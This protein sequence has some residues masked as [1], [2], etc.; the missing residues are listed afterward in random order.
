MRT[1]TEILASHP[2]CDKGGNGPN[3][4][5]SYDVVYEKLLEHKRLQVTHVLEVG[6][7]YGHSL[8]VWA[9]YFPNARIFG[10]DNASECPLW[11]SDDPRIEVFEADTTKPETVAAVMNRFSFGSF[12]FI[13]DDGLHR[14]FAQAV[15]YGTLKPYLA[16]DGTYV[17]ED[18]EDWTEAVKL[19][20][21]I[22]GT[23]ADLREMK[24]RHD[25]V[26]LYF[27]PDE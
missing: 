14:S 23:L 20:Q 4:L 15:T 2:N 27:T 12:D 10:I 16:K 18:L 19:Q 11:V 7:R 1:L 17:I 21:V 9:E 13:V 5:H 3:A 22:G 6:V 8:K 26:L 24:R 25:D